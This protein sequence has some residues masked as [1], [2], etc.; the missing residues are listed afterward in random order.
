MVANPFNDLEQ[1]LD[2]LTSMV[3]ELSRQLNLLHSLE[4]DNPLDMAGAAEFLGVTKS[5]IYK[6]THKRTI[7]HFKR[8][9]RIYFSKEELRKW[10]AHNRKLTVEEIK[11]QAK[12]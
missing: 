11:A 7:P 10:L 12:L 6:F 2:N 9:K 4:K 5:V 3:S 1:K 8:G